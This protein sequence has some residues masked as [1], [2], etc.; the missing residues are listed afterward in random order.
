MDEMRAVLLGNGSRDGVLEGVAKLRPQIERIVD[1]VVADFSNEIDLSE[2]EADVAIVFGGDGSILRAVH[3]M[4]ERQLPLLAVNLGTL[5]FL[6]SL[7]PDAVIPFLE[8]SQFQ[9]FK[10]REQLLLNCSVWREKEN[11]VEPYSITEAPASIRSF[12]YPFDW[13]EERDNRYCVGN[14]LV[15]NEA[16]VRGGPPFS[17]LHINLAIDGDCATTFRGDG[18]LVA[19]PV[20]S[21]GH[22]LS[23]GGP[24]LRNE[25]DSVVIT[26]L[27]PHTLTFRSVVD[28]ASRVYELQV[29]SGEVFIIIDGVSRQKINGNDLV[30]IRKAPFSFKMIRVPENKY[31]HNLQRKLGWGVDSVAKIKESPRLRSY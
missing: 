1:V 28:S 8:S 23:A 26:P 20:G 19:T 5:G 6:A 13:Q 22:N 29:V 12:A 30:V 15:V 4:G 25:I 31:Y 18:L 9:D 7:D 16:S 3:Q 17:I 27:S 24:I 11:G 10:V 21:T 14:Y 2:Y